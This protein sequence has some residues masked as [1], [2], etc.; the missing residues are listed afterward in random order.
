[1]PLTKGCSSKIRSENISELVH[2][3]KPLNQAIAIAIDFARRQKCKIKR[4]K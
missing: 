3:G 2:S 4:K 1:M